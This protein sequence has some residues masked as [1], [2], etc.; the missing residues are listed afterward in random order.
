MAQ[1]KRISI[2]E[3]AGPIPGLGGQGWGVAVSR[4]VGRRQGSDPALCGCGAGQQLWL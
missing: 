2:H 4:G 3:D 1:Q